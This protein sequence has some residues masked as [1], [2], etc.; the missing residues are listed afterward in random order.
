MPMKLIHTLLALALAIGA[1]A[2]P[3]S[4]VA[5]QH[6]AQPLAQSLATAPAA[7]PVTAA[8]MT[9]GVQA[10]GVVAAGSALLLDGTITNTSAVPISAGSVSISLSNEVITSRASLASWLDG[11][12]S[13]SAAG[14]AIFSQ[15]AP[16]IL[17]GRTVSFSVSIPSAS[18]PLSGAWGARRLL[19]QLTSGQTIES[20]TRSSVVWAPGGATPITPL[21]IAV[22]I[23]VPHTSESLIPAELLATYTG[24]SGVLTRQ[25]DEALNR[26]VT[27]AVDPMIVASIKILGDSVPESA[28]LWLQ[29]LQG[30]SNDSF[31]LSYADSDIA[32]GI[33]AGSPTILVPTSFAVN[34]RYFPGATAAT[35]TPSVSSSAEPPS[36]SPAPSPAPSQSSTLPTTQSLMALPYTITGFAWPARNSL[37]ETDFAALTN[38]GVTTSIVNSSNVIYEVTNR[39]Q[40]SGTNLG[41]HQVLVSDDTIAGLI[42]DA[43]GQVTDLGW[44]QAMT[45]LTASLAVA[46]AEQPADTRSLLAGLAR[47]TAV[48]G[49]RLAQTLTSLYAL[50]WVSASSVKALSATAS[51]ATLKPS[52][53]PAARLAQVS[54]L[55]A[56]EAAV[57][58]F[59]SVLADPTVLTGE[60]R[61]ALLATLGNSWPT[62]SGA[63]AEAVTKYTKRSSDLTASVKIASSSSL[64]LTSKN[65]HVDVTVQNSLEYPVTVIVSVR[66]PNGILTIQSPNRRQTIEA[67]S[68][69]K[70]TVPVTSL[71]NGDVT[72]HVSLTSITNVPIAQ[73]ALIQVDV[74][75]G[76]ETAFTAVIAALLVLVFGFGIFRNIRKRRKLKRSKRADDP[77][78]PAVE[79][80]TP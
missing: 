64:F 20:S 41:G 61:L 19:A 10:S 67:N 23:T 18:L 50:P 12:G 4:V 35:P 72:L 71:A 46:S 27:L 14:A 9:I 15:P 52:G 21:A 11:S 79:I 24:P 48:Q 26:T 5:A 29:T 13:D 32:A 37:I 3:G 38:S 68:Q 16:E 57:T 55:M 65:S 6:A 59:S 51:N 17:A 54:Q 56:S 39:I 36:E 66:A 69:A 40:N 22:P 63:W 49:G 31:A 44:E 34:A 78:T 60:R 75:A 74:Q 62:A 25:L 73:P 43:A 45:K 77:E 7:V 58:T 30:A 53:E 8:T 47:D 80:F 33:Q 76:W 70:A 28:R 2:V 1:V 42:D